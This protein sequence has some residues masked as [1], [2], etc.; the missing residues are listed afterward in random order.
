MAVGRKDAYKCSGMLQALNQASKEIRSDIR[1]SKQAMMQIRR[2]NR[3]KRD[4]RML[5][6]SSTSASAA[7]QGAV[8]AASQQP[9][10]QSRVSSST[11]DA[12]PTASLRVQ[13]APQKAADLVLV[14]TDDTGLEFQ[15]MDDLLQWQDTLP[16]VAEEMKANHLEY[17]QELFD[18][19]NLDT[20]AL[21]GER[22]RKAT[23]HYFKTMVS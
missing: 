21:V 16:D 19:L 7:E 23:K 18:K 8:P 2:G 3:L 17:V 5:L 10:Q 1:M 11:A 4:L 12:M 22:V 15:P 13:A 14:Q 9:A 6:R 20:D